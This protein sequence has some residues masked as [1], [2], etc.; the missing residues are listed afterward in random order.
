MAISASAHARMVG[1]DPGTAIRNLHPPCASATTS[2]LTCT[3]S[4][5]F[6]EHKM[7]TDKQRPKVHRVLSFLMF[8]R[9]HLGNLG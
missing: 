7:R 5:S 1:P 3:R 8:G 2:D 6:A 4:R 9:H